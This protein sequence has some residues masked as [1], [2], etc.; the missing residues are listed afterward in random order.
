ME[1]RD[2]DQGGYIPVESSPT[3]FKYSKMGNLEK[4]KK[5]VDSDSKS[6]LIVNVHPSY[7]Y[8]KKANWLEDRNNQ[9]MTEGYEEDDSDIKTTKTRN[10]SS[11]HSYIP[12]AKGPDESVKV[13]TVTPLSPFVLSYHCV[14][15]SRV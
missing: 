12:S 14:L 3:T 8:H 9:N 13:L 11:N 6:D 2:N 10:I 1:R 5:E 4:E 15:F 7:P